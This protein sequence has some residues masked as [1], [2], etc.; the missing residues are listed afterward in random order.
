MGDDDP[1]DLNR[2]R[3]PI[4][5]AQE[6]SRGKQRRSKWRRQWVRVPWGWVERLRPVKRGTTYQL[7]FLL[8]Y[9]HWRNGGRLT[10]LS[11]ILAREVGLSRQVKWRA[12]VELERRGLVKV[13]RRQRQAPRLIL[14][15]LESNHDADHGQGGV[16]NRGHDLPAS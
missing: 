2:F 5:R 11:N 9:E 12:L 13:E 16:T 14:R 7:A 1:F 15:H 8:L 4:E 6:I 10:V 3:A